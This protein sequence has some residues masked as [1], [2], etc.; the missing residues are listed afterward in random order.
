LNH[1]LNITIFRFKYQA[2]LF[3]LNIVL[4]VLQLYRCFYF[5]FS[6][7]L[8]LSLRFI[9]IFAQKPQFSIPFLSII[10]TVFIFFY[11]FVDIKYFFVIL[12]TS[13][14]NIQKTLQAFQQRAKN[15]K[16]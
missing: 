13:S 12:P 2:F 14:S 1:L 7:L 9:T 4:P 6:H 11:A 3:V 15:K 5:L 10:K 8:G 16:K